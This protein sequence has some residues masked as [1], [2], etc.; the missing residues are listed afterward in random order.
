MK[1]RIQKY[2]A[3]DKFFIEVT[4][5]DFSQDDLNLMQKF[6]EPQIDVGG[7]YGVV[8]TDTSTWILADR[9]IS[10]RQDFQPFIF[11]FDGRSYDD[12]AARATAIAAMVTTNI[13]TALTTLRALPDSYS[14]ESVT[15][16]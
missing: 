12:A 15:N 9:Y 8:D 2:I 5:E 10:L 11:F 6:G 13:Q 16:Y 14:G 7:L 4:T 1:I 3:D